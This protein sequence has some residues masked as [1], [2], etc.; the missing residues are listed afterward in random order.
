MR[1][2]LKEFQERAL[3]SM[4]TQLQ[5]ARNEVLAVNQPQSLALSSPTGSGKTVI[6]TALIESLIEGTADCPPDPRATFLWITDQPE[7]NEQTRNKMTAYFSRLWMGG[8]ETVEADFDQ[9]LFDP[10]KIYFLN[11]Q[12]LGKEKS[13]ISHGD[14]R[15]YTIWETIRNTIAD[16]P[17]P[18]RHER[19]T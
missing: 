14:G 19:D 12:K 7:L 1:L 16:S 5:L 18:S 2:V 15:T 6:M 8:L 17:P 9:Q 11:T 10:R 3:S 4:L 13:L